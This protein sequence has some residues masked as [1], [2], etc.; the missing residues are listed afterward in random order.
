M[1]FDF[2]RKIVVISLLTKSIIGIIRYN[3][4]PLN[5]SYRD[6]GSLIS[7]S[8]QGA[9]G[10]FIKKNF[11]KLFIEGSIARICYIS[12]HKIYQ[13]KLRGIL[14]VSLITLTKAIMN[15]IKPKLKLH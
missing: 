3:N 6:N 8:K 15:R 7:I 9:I 11:I 12:L 14:V 1:L 4:T 2:L 10:Y 5:Y 13:I